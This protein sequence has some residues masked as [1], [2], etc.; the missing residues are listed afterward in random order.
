MA[1]VGG[2]VE[3]AGVGDDIRQGEIEIG[4]AWYEPCDLLTADPDRAKGAGLQ[5]DAVWAAGL[6]VNPVPSFQ[7]IQTP[8]TLLDVRVV[9]LSDASAAVAAETRARTARCPSDDF[10]LN[11]GQATARWGSRA[12]TIDSTS[13]RLTTATV[14]R[15]NPEIDAG[16][17]YLPGDARLVFA[18]GPL[19]ISIE[20]LTLWPRK[21]NSAAEITAA[22]QEKAM[23]LAA[24]IVKTLPTSSEN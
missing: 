15:V 7:N 10:H 14:K 1:T 18:H 6:E 12:V 19:L 17:N 16:V 8:M 24:A 23:T 2:L 4:E 22:A 11:I 3:Q 20:A 9:H 13:A 5:L 21:Q